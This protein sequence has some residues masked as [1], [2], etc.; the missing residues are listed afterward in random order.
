MEDLERQLRDD[1]PW[2]YSPEAVERDPHLRQYDQGAV[3]WDPPAM[4]VM[5]VSL[6]DTHSLRGPRQS[7]K[8]TTVKRLIRRLIHA[9]E[10]RVLYFSFDTVRRSGAIGDVI[11]RSRQLHPTPEGPWHIFLD[12]ITSI[13]DWEYD[14]KRCWDSGL[15]RDDAIILTASSA[16]D[17]RFGAERLPGRRGRGR[18]FLQL[19]MSFRDFCRVRG[20]ALPERTLAA[21]E[22]LS[23]EG[24]QLAAHLYGQGQELEHALRLY[25][26][27]GGFPSAVRDLMTSQSGSVDE[28]TILLLNSVLAGDLIRMRRDP[29]SGIKLIQ[30]V[31]RSLGSPLKWSNAAEAMAVDNPTTAKEYA[32]LLAEIFILLTVHFWDIGRQSLEPH[33]QRKIYILDPL[34]AQLPS[35]LIPGTL[36]PEQD[37]LIEDI[38]A[39]GLFRSAASTLI[40]ASAVPTAVGYWRSKDDR[41]IDFVVPR[42]SEPNNPARFPIEVKGDNLTGIS[43]ARSSIKRTFKQGIITS[44]SRFEWDQDIPVLPVWL[45]LAGLSENASRPMALA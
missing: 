13:P 9:K 18:D 7:G 21:E 29:L 31:C 30:Q 11:R 28:T 41:E 35:A 37:G 14:L 24:R 34:Y 1:N 38:V 6:K 5:P 43:G 8:T 23:T 19:P 20:I 26:R 2:W 3:K 44:L 10:Q 27:V 45:L 12:E 25:L 16:R 4:M 40:Q 22:F 32:E 39:V 36:P 17:L 33:K 15:T 42:A